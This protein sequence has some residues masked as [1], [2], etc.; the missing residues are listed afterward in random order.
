MTL[1]NLRYL[2]TSHQY[3][4][5]LL[6]E[7]K[8]AGKP[9]AWVISIRDPEMKAPK[10]LTDGGATNYLELQFHDVESEGSGNYCGVNRYRAPSEWDAKHIVE[11]AQKIA[12]EGKDGD[13]VLVH[14]YAGISR[15]TAALF[16]VLATLTGEGN[17]EKNL[18]EVRKVRVVA[19]PN[20]LLVSW[21]D[22]V[23][24]RGGK[25]NYALTGLEKYKPKDDTQVEMG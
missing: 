1:P 3:A 4:E 10:G 20:T 23:L 12:T 7:A 14:C 21:G 8:Q 15:S 13:Q 18:A 5:E 6:S 16:L 19:D 2:V 24:R 25:L 11:F 9:I 17:E 22:Y